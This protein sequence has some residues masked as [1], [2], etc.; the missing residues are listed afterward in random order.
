MEPI[1]EN[2]TL[3]ELG[4]TL[5]TK[6][7][8]EGELK[9]GEPYKVRFI[10]DGVDDSETEVME[11]FRAQDIYSELESLADDYFNAA[12]TRLEKAYKSRE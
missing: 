8:E 3:G 6:G 5:L 4:V 1:S 12:S 2:F 11:N 9:E 10:V 7:C